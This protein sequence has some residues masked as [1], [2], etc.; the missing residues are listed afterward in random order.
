MKGKIQRLNNLLFKSK[1]IE[2]KNTILVV[3]SPRSGTTW[4]MDILCTMPGYTYLFEPL[5]PIWYPESFKVGF[6]SRTYLKSESNWPEGEN[7]LRKIFTGQVANLPI[8]DNP[9]SDL[10]QDFSMKNFINHLFGTKLIVK[11]TNM[12]RMLPWIAKHFQ[13]RCVFFIIR[14]P[15]ATIASQL[16]SGL[17]GYR[18][19]FPPYY[20]IFPTKNN[21]L[22][23]LAELDD[24]NSNIINKLKNIKTMEE[25]LAAS[26]CLD[27]FIPLSQSQPY[28][29]TTIIYEKLIKEGEKEI[30]RLFSKIGEKNIPKSAFYH[31]KKPTIVTLKEERKFITKSNQQLS[32][33]KKYLTEKQ[34]K[35]IIKIVSY[36]EIDYYTENTEPEYEKFNF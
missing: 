9:I 7:Y 1:K 5:N 13:L 3:G 14:H 33:W 16:K 6:R 21:I 15:C 32:K 25:I 10:L 8:K 17:Y 35:N 22:N 24:F 27:N 30:K 12:N 18:P 29:W 2:M 26:W 23:E 34:I 31:L 19:E 4:L 11:S 28:P 36:F 20:D